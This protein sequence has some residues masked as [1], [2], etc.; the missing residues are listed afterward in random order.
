M[1]A[2]HAGRWCAPSPVALVLATAAAGL[3]GCGQTGALYLPDDASATVITRPGP[4]TTSPPATGAATTGD[5]AAAP[6]APRSTAPPVDVPAK[7]TDKPPA[8]R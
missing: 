5:S 8:R 7:A 1:R 3:S 6:P 4:V 2:G